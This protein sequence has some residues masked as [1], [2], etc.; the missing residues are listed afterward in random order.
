MSDEATIT[1][2]DHEESSPRSKRREN[3]I[4]RFAMSGIMFFGVAGVLQVIGIISPWQ[5]D[6][7]RN[8]AVLFGVLAS[9]YANAY[10]RYR[11]WKSD[12]RLRKLSSRMGITVQE[13]ENYR[14]FRSYVAHKEMTARM[15]K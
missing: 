12:L 8:L 14:K 3:R 2:P 15:K 6:L 11:L 4:N 10:L 5:L 1:V 13:L 7:Y 9:L